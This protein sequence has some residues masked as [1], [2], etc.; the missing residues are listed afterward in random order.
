VPKGEDDPDYRRWLRRFDGSF[1][2]EDR[3][4]SLE[5]RD[6]VYQEGTWRFR[7]KKA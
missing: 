1:M 4:K 7:E 6:V 3:F 2:T 5:E